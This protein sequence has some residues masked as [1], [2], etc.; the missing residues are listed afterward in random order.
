MIRQQSNESGEGSK[1]LFLCSCTSVR[2]QS[3]PRPHSSVFRPDRGTCG[4]ISS[5]DECPPS[6]LS[7]GALLFFFFFTFS[8]FFFKAFSPSRVSS[9]FSP[10]TFFAF[11]FL[12]PFFFFFFLSSAMAA[13]SPFFFLRPQFSFKQAEFK[14]KQSTEDNQPI[15]LPVL[16]SRHQ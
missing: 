8:F 3:Q 7:T 1:S 9:L 15:S 14:N 13:W 10:S 4:W 11:P 6:V 12:P 2:V 16:L 5:S